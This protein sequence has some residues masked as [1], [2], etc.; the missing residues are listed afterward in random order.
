MNFLLTA[1]LAAQH[2]GRLLLRIDDVDTAR[3]RREYLDDVFRV[4]EW[5]GLVIDGG[6]GG[7]EEFRRSYSMADRTDHYRAAA[8]RLQQAE[9]GAFACRC[10]R[11]DLAGH[12]QGPYPGRCRELGLAWQ[13]GSTSLRARVPRPAVV[14]MGDGT[15]VDVA[16]TMGD[17]VVWRRDDIPAYQLASVIEDRDLGITEVVRG[18]DLL[19]SS[20]AQRL[21]APRVGAPGFAQVRVR[22]HGLLTG[23][24]GAKL[25]KSTARASGSIAGDADLLR[26]IHD[27]ARGFAGPIG[28][29]P[30]S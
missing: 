11:R 4:I 22:H 28:I 29:V 9:P 18:R 17:F 7:V 26:R 16:A 13:P 19:P 3:T 20:A 23:P 1:W 27:A 10:S 30:P 12:G 5:L 24:D 14:P 6:P 25:S 8:L 2:G 15:E 21:L